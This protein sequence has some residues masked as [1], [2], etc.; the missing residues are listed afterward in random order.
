MT[1]R[2]AAIKLVYKSV[3]GRAPFAL[4][5]F[6]QMLTSWS[7][8]PLYENGQVIG[9]VLAKDNELHVGYG[10]KPRAS[11]R[12]YIKEILGGVID[13]YGCAVTTVQADNPAGL[14]FC[15]RLGFVK[16]SEENGTIRLRCDRSNFS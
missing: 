13:K 14:R 6:V 15:E 1:E 12:P 9:G 16:L 5:E 2:D 8:V 11:I 4:E 3:R 7:V 10:E